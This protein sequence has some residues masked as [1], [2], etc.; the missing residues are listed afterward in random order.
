MPIRPHDL[1]DLY[2]APVALEVDRRLEEMADLSADD[3]RYRVILSTDREPGTAEEREESLLEALTRG[4]DLHGWQ[5]S[6][7]PRGLSLSHDA[8]GL[9]LG[10]PANLVSYLDG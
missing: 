4:I 6:R 8:Y 1:A 2:L 10:I 7:H 5:V 9:V 3:V